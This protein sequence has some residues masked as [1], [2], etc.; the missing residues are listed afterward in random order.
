MLLGAAV[1]V[2]TGVGLLTGWNP[3]HFTWLLA[4]GFVKLILLAAVGLMAA[5]AVIIR[6][7]RRAELRDEA[8]RPLPLHSLRGSPDDDRQR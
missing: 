7:E 4:V 8:A 2:A 5:G 6:L 1:G 3:L